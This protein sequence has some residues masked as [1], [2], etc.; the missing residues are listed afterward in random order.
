MSTVISETQPRGSSEGASV[1]EKKG[2]TLVTNI[3]AETQNIL[4]DDAVDPIYQAKARILNNALQEIG[5]G[6]YQVRSIS[7]LSGKHYVS[8]ICHIVAP[9]CRDG[10]WLACVRNEHHYRTQIG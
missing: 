7:Y 6:K 8:R 1:S 9:L 3:R 2:D 4:T 5:M 10:I